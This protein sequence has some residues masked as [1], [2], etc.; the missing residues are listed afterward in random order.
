MTELPV[1]WAEVAIGDVVEVNPRKD[2]ALAEDAV[3]SFVPMA[4]VDEVSG[5]ITR[6]INR[7]YYEVAR[8]FTQFRDQDVIFAKITPSMENGKSA[9]ARD[10]SNG[11]GLGSTEFHVLRTSDAIE[12]DYLWRF[13]RQQS[14]RDNAQ[15][16]MTGA[17]GQQRVP[18]D[19]LRAHRIPL[20][21][22]VEQRRIIVK[23][24]G[25]CDR[26]TRARTELKCIP[27]LVARYKERLIDM[28]LTGALEGESADRS[29]FEIRPFSHVIDSTFYG[30]RFAKKAYTTAGIPTIRTTDFDDDGNIALRSP[31]TVQVSERDFAKWALVDGDVLVTRTGSIG[32][33]AV[34]SSAIG[35]ALPSAYLIRVRLNKQLMRPKFALLFLRSASGQ[36]QLGA[37]ITAVAQPNINAKVIESLELPIPT[38]QVQDRI[39]IQI[40]S[41]LGWLSR[42][43]VDHEAAAKLLP[44]L[45]AAIVER[46]FRGK[47]V[48]QDPNE[49]SA[50]A[51]INRILAA[52][53]GKSQRSAK[54]TR[55]IK[56]Q[57]G[58]SRLRP[59]KGGASIVSKSR[60]DPDVF[61]Q[62]YLA[63]MLRQRLGSAQPETLFAEADLELPDF[64]K[65]LSDEF[66]EGW[67]VDDDG[68]LKAAA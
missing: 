30:P 31:P 57:E 19:Y 3:V 43:T 51:L 27:S 29:E 6:A 25:L 59:R 1:G 68:W 33:C 52:R 36:R 16:V 37:G 39:I 12:P 46:A 9:V 21:P 65:Q 13:I 62:P 5:T 34:Y 67:I 15:G 44:K 22:L 17:V 11:V 47:L 2:V 18:A 14:F 26:L 24:G 38:V 61:R 20:P 7:P 41:A 50:T 28:A 58:L 64:Y 66:D 60:H 56:H 48:P 54:R 49:E 45:E 32:K 10:L 53:P 4:A 55:S 42:V 8:G 35:P 63:A 23:I 40:E